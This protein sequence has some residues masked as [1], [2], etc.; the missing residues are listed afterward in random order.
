MSPEQI[1]N[2]KIKEIRIARTNVRQTEKDKELDELKASIKK[3][4]LLQPVI[5]LG[6]FDN[7]P[8]S[9]IVGQRRFLAHQELGKETIRARFAGKLT[10]VQQTIRSL[11]E[12]MVR[13][14]LNHAD[15]AST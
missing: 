12:N 15:A 4:G 3:H 7:P 8:Y 2:I 9:L 5:L 6:T 1:Y 10:D 11:V 14:E 13:V